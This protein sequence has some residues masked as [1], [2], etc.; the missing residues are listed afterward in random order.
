MSKVNMDQINNGLA[1][2]FYIVNRFQ[3]WY[4]YTAELSTKEN[5][6]LHLFMFI[7]AV[8]SEEHIFFLRGGDA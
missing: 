4:M 5:K 1:H 7:V 3:N 6:P 8:D 2:E